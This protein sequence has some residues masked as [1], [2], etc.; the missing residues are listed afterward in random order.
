MAVRYHC[1]KCTY[2]LSLDAPPLNGVTCPSCRASLLPQA[3]ATGI[4]VPFLPAAL[5]QT[6]PQAAPVM[7]APKLLPTKTLRDNPW[8]RYAAIASA[9]VVAVVAV[10]VVLG[11]TALSKHRQGVA[12]ASDPGPARLPVEN[13]DV[14]PP[15]TDE[16]PPY[17]V[18]Q[19]TPE[20]PPAATEKSAPAPE[21]PQ[22]PSVAEAPPSKP[23]QEPPQPAK[24]VE[25][26]PAKRVVVFKRFD[27]SSEEDLRKQLTQVPQ[28]ALDDVPR[29]SILI[30]NAAKRMAKSDL[31]FQ[32]PAMLLSTRPDLQGLPLR[33]GTDCQVGKE[34]AEN[35]QVLSR[36]MRVVLENTIPKDGIDLRPNVDKL[37]S[38][39]LDDQK[40]EW[41]RP[42][43]VPCLLQLLQAENS[44][45]RLVMVECLG[46][47][48]DRRATQALAMRAM[49]DLNPE[50]RE[51]AARELLERPREDYEALLLAGLR[52]P[53]LPVAL[54]A[55]ET[56]VFLKDVAVLPQLVKLLDQPDTTMPFTARQGSKEISMI[57]EVVRINHL[58]NCL[59]CHPASFVRTDMVRGAV[60]TPGQALPPPSTPQQYYENGSIFVHADTTYLKQDFSVMQPV[61]QH[62]EWP[63]YQRFDYLVRLRKPTVLEAEI[64]AKEKADG[65]LTG[66][67]EA[68]LFA[69]RELSGKDSN[70]TIREL[71]ALV[72]PNILTKVEFGKYEEE[73]GSDWKQFAGSAF[74]STNTSA[75]ANA[76][77]LKTRLLTV[78]SPDE[79]QKILAQLR[80]GKGLPYTDALAEVIVLLD[81]PSLRTMARAQLVERL[82][83]MTDSTLRERLHED[84]VEMRRAAAAAAEKRKATALIPDL[85]ALLSDPDEQVIRAAHWALVVVAKED[86][87][88]QRDANQDQRER[89]VELWTKW[90]K[91][92]IGA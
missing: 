78:F 25:E 73:V 71:K 12:I 55:A 59:M 4:Q 64:L 80:D 35:L 17:Q 82:E 66:G 50:I 45:V 54:H 63:E 74:L 1:D 23:L 90:W 52:Y 26:R 27:K 49:M 10:T 30:E 44:P 42:E 16:T 91:A 15:P 40:Q 69:A 70:A 14:T 31:P 46:Q 29:T 87:G 58:S 21:K 62:G 81:D 11:W 28:I 39:L 85:I 76:Q 19:A 36:K 51:T 7:T 89:A 72:E 92:K 24:P 38:A 2:Q 8:P 3:E 56:L 22:P 33:L 32:G 53:W 86:F 13:K 47:I 18:P 57:R 61:P 60:P 20:Q 6:T 41:L 75:E 83:R 77:R 37:R 88:P 65:K 68:V 9:V 34:P 84:N 5:F 48:K 43:A 79:Q 67:N